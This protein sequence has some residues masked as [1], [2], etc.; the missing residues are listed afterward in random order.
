MLVAVANGFQLI[1][2]SGNVGNFVQV[3]RADL[4][5]VQVDQVIVVSVDLSHL[6]VGK[7]LG[8]EPVRDVNVLMRECN[9]R[10]SVVIARSLLVVDTDVALLLGFIYLE[11]KV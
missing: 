4:T 10:M 7:I 6:I 2:V 5:D 9:R 11:V 8:I 1:E 3:L